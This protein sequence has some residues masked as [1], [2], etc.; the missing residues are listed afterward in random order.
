MITARK[1]SQDEI[2]IFLNN[3]RLGQVTEMKYLGIYF[4]SR[5]SFTST[6]NT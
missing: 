6:Q 3:S 1:R 2:K 4:D 5:L